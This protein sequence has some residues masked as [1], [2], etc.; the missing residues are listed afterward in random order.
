MDVL[1]QTKENINLHKGSFYTRVYVQFVIF[2]YKRN[3]FLCVGDP[4]PELHGSAL[5]LVGWIRIRIQVGKTT[6][7]RKKYRNEWV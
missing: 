3:P 7:N 6:T 4:D 5:I 1:D 2:L